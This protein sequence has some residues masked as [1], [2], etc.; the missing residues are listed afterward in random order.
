MSLTP[1]LWPQMICPGTG[2][3]GRRLGLGELVCLV[4][5]WRRKEFYFGYSEFHSL[6]IYSAN[7]YGTSR[8]KS[9]LYFREGRR[10][11]VVLF[12]DEREAG[13]KLR[14]AGW[15]AV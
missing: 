10:F 1:R 14:S 8:Q 11:S 7:I 5:G 15:C 13:K 3:K 4:L 12:K 6:F 9:L 2:N